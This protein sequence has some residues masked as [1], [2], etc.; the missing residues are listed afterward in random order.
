MNT[1]TPTSA[2]ATPAASTLIVSAL[3]D[4]EYLRES[5]E[6]FV[7]VAMDERFYARQARERLAALP[8]RVWLAE[9]AA[10]HDRDA[11]DYERSAALLVAPYAVNDWYTPEGALQVAS[12][13]VAQLAAGN[14]TWRDLFGE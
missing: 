1:P 12:L 11:A 8:E 13:L 5:F 6:Q 3:R 10:A 4:S 2:S 7:F 9:L 14:M